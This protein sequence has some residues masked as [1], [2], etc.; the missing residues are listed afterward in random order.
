MPGKPGILYA[1]LTA[2]PGHRFMTFTPQQEAACDCRKGPLLV[3][4]G[5][6][7]GKTRTLTERIRR[8]VKLDGV[9]P[10]RILA[11]TFTRRAA[12]EMRSRLEKALGDTARD[13]EIATFHSFC[14]R[15]IQANLDLAG[16]T[17]KVTVYDDA[18]MDAMTRQVQMDLGKAAT[19]ETVAGEVGA[20]LQ[21]SNAVTYDGILDRAYRVLEHADRQV[22]PCTHLSID[23]YQDVND[24]QFTIAR[25]LGKQCESL[26]VVGDDAQSIYAFRGAN[27]G[28]IL[29]FSETWPEAMVVKLEQNFRS[30]IPIVEAGNR[31]IAL[32]KTQ[33]PKTCW[34]DRQGP[35]YAIIDHRDI[36][37]TLEASKPG[38]RAVIAR[39]H[40]VLNFIASGLER[41]G[42]PFQRCNK[43]ADFFRTPEA[44][45]IMAPIRLFVNPWDQIACLH[46]FD[47]LGIMGAER[48]RVALKAMDEGLGLG[49]AILAHYFP[50]V[51][52]KGVKWHNE[53]LAPLAAVPPSAADRYSGWIE[54]WTFAD[55]V[56][57][58]RPEEL[59]EWVC[60]MDI[61]DGLQEPA[62]TEK[63]SLL[64][65]HAAKG[66][67]FDTVVVAGLDQSFPRRG[68]RDPEEERRCMYVALT[69]AK[70]RLYLAVPDGAEAS[71][72][73]AELEEI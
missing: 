70:D 23:E 49:S 54:H 68:S 56:R 24:P 36:P 61:Q 22:I 35:D 7:S 21:Q 28:Q 42:V 51:E 44:K 45:Q 17:G 58:P 47:G 12:R 14:L 27:M 39:T 26:M 1:A 29:S 34:S 71:A 11:I 4:A 10:S 48:S 33:M 31:L 63:V 20:R 73:I 46:A 43:A 30:T 16:F 18:D 37:S 59:L 66:L 15:V 50:A 6:G 65:I 69:R 57:F 53:I 25:A 41:E 8:M 13:I 5:A 9:P 38:T 40:A 52:W 3:I 55:N 67:E 19:Q 72:Y 32:N 62:E 2:S 64:T 60:L